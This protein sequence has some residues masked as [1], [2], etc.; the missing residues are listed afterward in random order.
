MRKV[1]FALIACVAAAVTLL[2]L[3]GW[4]RGGL[5]LLQIGMSICS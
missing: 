4:R 5:D 3:H 1:W 2:I